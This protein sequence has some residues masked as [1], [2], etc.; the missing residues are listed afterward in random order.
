MTGT[1][2]ILISVIFSLAMEVELAVESVS[3]DAL[4]L[5]SMFYCFLV[6]LALELLLMMWFEEI[7]LIITSLIYPV[8]IVLAFLINLLMVL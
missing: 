2:S 7:V 4:Q 6:D 1:S 3:E 8:F 5:A